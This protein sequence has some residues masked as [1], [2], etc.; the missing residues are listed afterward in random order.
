MVSLLPCIV[1]ILVLIGHPGTMWALL[2]L[3][4]WLCSVKPFTRHLARRKPHRQGGGRLGQQTQKTV[5][6][7]FSFFFLLYLYTIHKDF[8]L[9]DVRWKKWNAAPGYVNL[10]PICFYFLIVFS[11]HAWVH[12]HTLV[13][14]C[15]FSRSTLLHRI[16]I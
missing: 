4:L 5:R 7:N 2:W 15:M 16:M 14:L 8:H 3:C 1:P 11:I 12:T 9:T 10:L 6:Q 13:F